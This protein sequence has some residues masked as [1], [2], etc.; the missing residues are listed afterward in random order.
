MTKSE[1]S[2][3]YNDFKGTSAADFRDFSS[4]DDFA[5]KF[6]IDTTKFVPRGISLYCSYDNFVSVSI[7]CE[8]VERENKLISIS[9]PDMPISDFLNQFKRLHII[10][11][12]RFYQTAKEIEEVNLEDIIDKQSN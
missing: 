10:L 1:A 6:A 11:F 4:L 12:K 7:I 3:Q 2:V 9:L 8:D 5:T